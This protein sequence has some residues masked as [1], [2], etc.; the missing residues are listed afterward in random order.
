VAEADLCGEQVSAEKDAG[1]AEAVGVFDNGQIANRTIETARDLPEECPPD[2]SRGI[3]GAL[4]PFQPLDAPTESFERFLRSGRQR[5]NP[6]RRHGDFENEF[7]PRGDHFPGQAD[8]LLRRILRLEDHLISTGNRTD[9]GISAAD[10]LVGRLFRR[11][12]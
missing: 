7:S 2:E 1:S 6:V 10:G 5:M 9:R 4:P 8:Y 3:Y 11:P 12:K